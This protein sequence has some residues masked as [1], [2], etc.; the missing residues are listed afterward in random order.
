RTP[1]WWESPD[2]SRVL[3]EYLAFGYSIGAY[4]AWHHDAEGIGGALSSALDLVVPFSAR[5][6]VLVTVG[7][8]HAIAQQELAP[9]LP[10]VNRVAG[11]DAAFGSIS[12]YLAGPPPDGV[13]TWRGELRSA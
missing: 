9:L 1:F 12:S 3:T 13:P 4:L 11:V 10:E 8:D 2:G 5:G 7:S 6:A